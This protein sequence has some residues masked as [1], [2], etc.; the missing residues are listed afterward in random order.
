MGLG[1]SAKL[2]RAVEALEWEGSVLPLPYLRP[3][4]LVFCGMSILDCLVWDFIY[5]VAL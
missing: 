5:D 3:R 1:A 4:N 2:V